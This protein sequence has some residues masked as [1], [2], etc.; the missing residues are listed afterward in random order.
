MRIKF[1][2]NKRVVNSIIGRV[3]W[4]RIGGYPHVTAPLPATLTTPLAGS[5][6]LS[7]NT[8]AGTCN[9]N[10]GG[11][12]V[13][14][15][16]VHLLYEGSPLLEWDWVNQRWSTGYVGITNSYRNASLSGNTWQITSGL[17][18]GTNQKLGRYTVRLFSKDKLGNGETYSAP[19]FTVSAT[20]A[21]ATRSISSATTAGPTPT[22]LPSLPQKPSYFGS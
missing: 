5:T 18:S 1:L 3:E 16:R 21:S 15:L 14:Q 8:L 17:P 4:S 19:M 12:G 22:P 6:V 2:A 20:A 9:D 13:G 7:F 11:V 10:T